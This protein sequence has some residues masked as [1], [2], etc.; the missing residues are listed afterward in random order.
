[1]TRFI[2]ARRKVR[3]MT[4]SELKPSKLRLGCPI[5]RFPCNPPTKTLYTLLNTRLGATCLAHVFA[6]TVANCLS[7]SLIGNEEGFGSCKK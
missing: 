3:Y 5:G 7:S 2:I 6:Q 4:L 1:M